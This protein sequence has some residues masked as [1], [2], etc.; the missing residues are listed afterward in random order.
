MW[1]DWNAEQSLLE[2][3]VRKHA[4][5]TVNDLNVFPNSPRHCVN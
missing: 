4:G 3:D 5:A 2:F 1:F